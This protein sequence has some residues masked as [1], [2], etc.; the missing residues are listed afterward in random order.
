MTT[1]P[2]THVLLAAQTALLLFLCV[3]VIAIDARTDRIA[4]DSQSAVVAQAPARQSAPAVAR[5]GGGMNADEVRTIVREEINA[6]ETWLA[7][8]LEGAPAAPRP[9]QP[10]ADPAE[11]A[12]LSAAV[13]KDISFYI[14]SGRASAAEM[15]ALHQKIARLPPADRQKALAEI[16]RAI[17]D[18]RLDARY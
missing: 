9:P 18:G 7:A 2:L 6:L 12:R 5:G 4:S 3:R 1:T 15:E 17:N 10:A 13:D 14:S 11:T 8:S 16:N